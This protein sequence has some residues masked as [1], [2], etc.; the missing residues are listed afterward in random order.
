MINY[1][2]PPS[3]I[4]LN[5]SE[6]C[7]LKCR[8]CSCNKVGFKQNLMSFETFKD[9]INQVTAYNPNAFLSL[10]GKGEPLLNMDCMNMIKY[11]FE[12]KIPVIS[13]T[14]NGT[15]LNDSYQKELLSN[16]N[17]NLG[18]SI[19]IDGLKNAYEK[20]RIGGDY[21]KVV[22][23]VC[24]LIELKKKLNNKKVI[25]SVNMTK[26]RHKQDELNDYV[27]F[28]VKCGI[29]QIV[30]RS[31]FEVKNHSF[32]SLWLDRALLPEFPEKQPC[33]FLYSF[34]QYEFTGKINHLCFGPYGH[35]KIV[36]FH[37]EKDN[38]KE[39]WESKIYS[40]LRDFHINNPDA[41][42]PLCKNCDIWKIDYLSIIRKKVT[43]EGKTC[44][45]LKNAYLNIYKILN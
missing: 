5:I 11:A 38:I 19:S 25:I 30:I 33:Q 37:S 40:N 18:I 44:L 16:T 13:L 26:I 23:N 45:N 31:L 15:L 14:S 4:R 28:W 1:L 21:D 27:R 32:I 10:I 39:I 34:L 22:E 7:N 3:K 9:I 12:R 43:I 6:A 2:L 20:I 24:N 8:M 41:Y 35:N 17:G 36:D 42:S 29:D